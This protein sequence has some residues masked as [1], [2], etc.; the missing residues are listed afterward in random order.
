MLRLAV[1]ATALVLTLSI[2]PTPAAAQTAVRFAAYGD[3]PY[4]DAER[5]F[6]AG[7]AAERIAGDAA[8]AFVIALGDLGRPET[9][10]ADAWQIA[11]RD[12]WRDRFRKPVFLTPGDN[13]WT[14]CDRRS[15]PNRT[16]ELARLDAMRRIHFAAPPALVPAGWGYQ[17]QPGQPENATWTHGGVRFATVHLVSTMNG[18]T[19]ILLDDR[20]LAVALA[21]TRDLANRIWLSRIFAQARSAGEKAVVIAMQADPFDPGMIARGASVPPDSLARCLAIPAMARTCEAL[22]QEV[23]GFPGPV[24]LVHGDTSPAC[25]EGVGSAGAPSPGG[26]PLFWRLNAWGDGST[27]ADIAIVDVDPAAAEPFRVSGVQAGHQMPTACEY[28]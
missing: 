15:V 11:Q 26:K 6:L 3:M 10:C 2:G 27:P 12:L 5:D 7:P 22:V 13:D 24:L 16:S 28:R 21:D 20:D 18:R 1:L 19:E 23:R 8:I 9:A 4:S 17:A 25:L 14:D